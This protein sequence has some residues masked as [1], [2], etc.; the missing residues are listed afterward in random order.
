MSVLEMPATSVPAALRRQAVHGR[1]DFHI[2]E[3]MA[4]AWRLTKGFKASFWGAAVVVGAIALVISTVLVLAFRPL[5]TPGRRPPL[6]VAMVVNGALGAA[7]TPFTIGLTMMCVRRAQ[8]LPVSFSTAFSYFSKAGRAT[9]A[10]ALVAL[11]TSIGTLLFV[12]PGIYLNVAL[13]LTVPLIGDQHIS[14]WLAMETS[15]KAITHKWFRIFGLLLL[16]GLLTCLSSL[17]LFI[18]LFWTAPWSM[19][20]LAVLYRR[21]FCAAPVTAD[22]RTSVPGGANVQTG[23]T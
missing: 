10:G 7:I 13:A 1:Y 6:W 17:A 19:M 23:A 5:L 14:A 20:V 12:L 16:T 4:E 3:V 22:A 11:A 2:G 15:R 8:G 9:V 21:V 18:P